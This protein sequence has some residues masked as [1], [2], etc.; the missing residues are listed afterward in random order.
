MRPLTPVEKTR[1]ATLHDDLKLLFDETRK[2]LETNPRPKCPDIFLVCGQ[3]GKE[4]QDEAVRKG[5]S[6]V[7][8][9]SSKHNSSPSMAMD[10][11]PHPIN[12]REVDRFYVMYN[13]MK[14]V[15]ERLGLKIRFGADFNQDGNLKN[16]KFVDMPHC[17]I[18]E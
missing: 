17:E 18:V 6:K 11:C 16:D 10:T 5:L 2:E 8:F 3:R 9:P 13:V 7:N 1:Y 14:E 12:W 15:A 4:E